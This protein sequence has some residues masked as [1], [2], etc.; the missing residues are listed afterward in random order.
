MK[1]ILILGCIAAAVLAIFFSS[2]IRKIVEY[3][4][5]IVATTTT[6]KTEP[7]SLKNGHTFSVTLPEQYSIQPT[8]EGLKRIRFMAWSPDR[9]LFLTDMYDL[10]DNTKGKIYIFDEF[11]EETGTFATSTTYLSNLRNPNSLTFYRDTDGQN[12][13][14]IAL[15]DK[16]IRY[17]YEPGDMKPEAAPHVI[18]VFPAYG[19]SYK[20]GG[21]HLTRTVEIHDDKVYVSVGSS[22]NTCEEKEPERASIIQMDPDG[23]NPRFFAKGLRNAVGMTWVNDELFATNMGSDHLGNDKPSE[24]MYRIKPG[25]NYGWP[26]CYASNGFIHEDTTIKWLRK[27]INCALVPGPDFTFPA[28]AAPLGLEYIAPS[29]EDPYLRDSFLVALHGASDLKIGTGYKLVKVK[30]DTG[31]VTDFITGFL[32]DGIRSGRPV[33]VLLYN[34]N[35]F[36]FTDDFKGVLY[37]VS[38]K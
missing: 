12:W 7:I 36:F 18:A 1:R 27:N 17:T 38:R 6:F 8:A 9:R 34:D 37:F 10:T 19:N 22:C 2:R 20:Y 21:W 13:I 26:Y 16:L 28:H 33:D 15:T 35:S 3:Q 31:E 4:N 24:M 14:Y 32:H 5:P 29:F 23:S 30:R 11:N 25:T